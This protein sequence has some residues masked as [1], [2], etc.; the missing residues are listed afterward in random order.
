MVPNSEF[1]VGRTAHR[2]NSSYYTV[3]GRR[4]TYKEATRT[5]RSFGIDLDH[6]RFLILQ[7]FTFVFFLFCDSLHVL[8]CKY[9]LPLRDIDFFILSFSGL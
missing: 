3:N 4:C 2:D 1:V 9:R 6:N 8:A 7:V 5:L